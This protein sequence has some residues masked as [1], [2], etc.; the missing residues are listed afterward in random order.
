[1]TIMVTRAS[2]VLQMNLQPGVKAE[3]EDEDEK[4]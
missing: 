4:N 2:S 1:M 3:D